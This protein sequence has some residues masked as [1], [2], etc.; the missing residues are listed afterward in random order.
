MRWFATAACVCGFFLVAIPVVKSAEKEAPK[1]APATY[2]GSEVCKACHAPAFEKFSQTVMG[3]IFLHNPRNEAE[4]QRLR[5]L[6]RT[7]KQSRVRRGR[8][9]GRRH[10]QL[11]KE[12]G[13]IGRAAERSLSGLSSERHPG[14]LEGEHAREPRYCLHELPYADGEDQRQANCEAYRCHGFRHKSRGNRSLRSVSLATQGAAYALLAYADAGGKDR[15]L[16]LPQSTWRS[17]SGAA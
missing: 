12:F 9:R 11:S 6:S 15:L 16:R 10:D 5:K 2:V 3:K 14:F 4:K 7:G 1:P 8:Q 17:Q 13:G